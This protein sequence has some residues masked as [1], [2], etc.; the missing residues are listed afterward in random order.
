M[1]PVTGVTLPFTSYGGSSLIASYTA[2]GLLLSVGQNRPLTL[3]KE[4]FVFDYDN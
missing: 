1:M 4:S 3:G 2:A